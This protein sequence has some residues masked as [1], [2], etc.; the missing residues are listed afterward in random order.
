MTVSSTSSISSL[1]FINCETTS[2]PLKPPWKVLPLSFASLTATTTFVFLFIVRFLIWWIEEISSMICSVF[3]FFYLLDSGYFVLLINHEVAWFFIFFVLSW[4]SV[5]LNLKLNWLGGFGIWNK[6]VVFCLCERLVN[7]KLVIWG[8][9][10]LNWY[11]EWTKEFTNR[12]WTMVGE[13]LM[14][15]GKKMKFFYY[16]KNISNVLKKLLVEQVFLL[17]FQIWYMINL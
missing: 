5:A 10:I 4:I 8:F 9:R 15:L 1:T 7:F 14:R 2:T 16:K 17:R 12:K 13:E 6:L 11:L 3:V